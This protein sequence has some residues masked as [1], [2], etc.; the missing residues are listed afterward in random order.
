MRTLGN[1][2]QRLAATVPACPHPTKAQRTLVISLGRDVFFF[3]FAPWSLQY[4]G[5]Q[6]RDIEQLIRED[7]EGLL[8]T[9]G[10]HCISSPHIVEFSALASAKVKHVR[11]TLFELPIRR[12]LVYTMGCVVATG[13]CGL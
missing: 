8:G 12:G 11:R 10:T 7:R 9:L 13:W 6:I 3:R 1:P 5:Q 4:E 2:N